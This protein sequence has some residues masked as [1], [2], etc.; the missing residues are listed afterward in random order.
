MHTTQLNKW[1]HLLIP[2]QII[3]SVYVSI[4]ESSRW[5]LETVPASSTPA[6]L[7]Y[8][9]HVLASLNTSLYSSVYNRLEGTTLTT[10]QPLF[11]R[12]VTSFQ[13]QTLQISRQLFQAITWFAAHVE[14]I[15]LLYS[16]EN[17]MPLKKPNASHF[18][19]NST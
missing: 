16:T 3:F 13:K 4:G 10:K 17:E 9:T 6:V 5:E 1:M 2:S 7:T 8:D 18:L 14:N 11:H 19:S 12:C 15:K